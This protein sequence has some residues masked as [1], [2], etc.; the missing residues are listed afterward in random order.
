VDRV[1]PPPAGG[2][3]ALCV[4][5]IAYFG[6][7]SG[8]AG[9]LAAFVGLVSAPEGGAMEPASPPGWYAVRQPRPAFSLT[10]GGLSEPAYAV[11]HHVPGGGRKDIMTFGEPGSAGAF[12]TVEVYRPGS[13]LER[14]ADPLQEATSEAEALGTILRA[15][16]AP[17]IDSK[18]GPV[19]VVDVT[20]AQT[21]R[22][23]RCLAFARNF[24]RPR[25]RISGVY[26]EPG[27]QIV[28]RPVVACA[29]DRL[30]LM[31]ADGEAAISQFFAR[32]ELK[33]TFCARLPSAASRPGD[34]IDAKGP[35]ALR[36]HLAARDE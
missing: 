22:R 8:L 20:V 3:R 31:S 34:W 15:S 9:L 25:L 35:P 36:G 11:R 33:R 10:I 19:G 13:E 29:L 32:A 17:A 24:E 16:A 18:F 21:D 23:R 28:N 7:L 2:V 27:A 12:A 26:C 30:S 6:G 14:F 5:L 4:S 1:A